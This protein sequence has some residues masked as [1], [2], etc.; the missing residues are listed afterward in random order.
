MEM[1]WLYEHLY[2]LSSFQVAINKWTPAQ[3]YSLA[4]LRGLDSNQRS[5]DGQTTRNADFI[6]FEAAKP[7]MPVII[8]AKHMDQFMAE[9]IGGFIQALTIRKQFGR[10]YGHYRRG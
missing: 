7:S 6:Q 4:T 8:L 3:H 5:I 9:H 2:Q 10:A 1:K